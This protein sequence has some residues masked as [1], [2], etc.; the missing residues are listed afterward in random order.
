[1]RQARQSRVWQDEPEEE[2]R[3]ASQVLL[4][5]HRLRRLRA[6]RTLLLQHYGLLGHALQYGCKDVKEKA[7]E[8]IKI[9]EGN[10]EMIR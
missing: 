5:V 4:G 7:E 9:F 2:E 6:P 1:M 3:P 8:E 10:V